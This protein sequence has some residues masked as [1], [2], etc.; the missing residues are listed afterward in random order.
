[1]YQQHAC[2]S[3]ACICLQVSLGRKP[4]I[5][6]NG[7]KA[8]GIVPFDPAIFTEEDFLPSTITNE[9]QATASENGDVEEYEETQE[10]EDAPTS[11]SSLVPQPQ[12]SFDPIQPSTSKTAMR[13]PIQVPPLLSLIS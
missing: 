1:M 2:S 11:F 3:T 5:A 4:S 13:I 8:C 9:E 7:F 12:S 6:V 10:Q